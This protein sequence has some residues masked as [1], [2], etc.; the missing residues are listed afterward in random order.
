MKPPLSWQNSCVQSQQQAQQR[1]YLIDR[2]RPSPSLSAAL[3]ACW[4]TLGCW[5]SA[6][7]N[8]FWEVGARAGYDPHKTP[9]G[10]KSSHRSGYPRPSAHAPNHSSQ[11]TR[12]HPQV[13]GPCHGHPGSHGKKRIPRLCR[14]GIPPGRMG[15]EK[16]CV[17]CQSNQSLIRVPEQPPT[18][19]YKSHKDATQMRNADTIISHFYR[20]FGNLKENVRFSNHSLAI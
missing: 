15:P 1:Q 19:Y 20:I 9:E 8:P 6:Q 5:A 13:F 4:K 14:S 18:Q 2:P 10:I 7:R 16:P 11:R 17:Y 12:T 3:R